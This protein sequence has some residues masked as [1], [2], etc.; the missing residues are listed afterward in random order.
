MDLAEMSSWDFDDYIDDSPCE[1]GIFEHDFMEDFVDEPY[2]DAVIDLDDYCF[3]DMICESNDDD[4]VSKEDLIMLMEDLENESI[5]SDWIN[6]LDIMDAEIN[7]EKKPKSRFSILKSLFP[8]PD[9][10]VIG[11]PSK[12]MSIILPKEKDFEAWKTVLT[13][14]KCESDAEVLVTEVAAILRVHTQTGSTTRHVIL[15][16]IN[17]TEKSAIRRIYKKYKIKDKIQDGSRGVVTVNRLVA[18][19]PE[20]MAAGLLRNPQSRWCDLYRPCPYF[21]CFPAAASLIPVRDTEL[22]QAHQNWARCF[23]VTVRHREFQECFW[24][25]SLTN[26]LYTTGPRTDVLQVLFA[27]AN[28]LNDR[29]LQ[30]C[31]N[32]PAISDR[33]WM[34]TADT[35]D[36][37]QSRTKRWKEKIPELKDNDRLLHT[38]RLESQLMMATICGEHNGDDV[39]KETLGNASRDP[40]T[41]GTGNGLNSQQSNVH[42]KKKKKKKKKVHSWPN[43]EKTWYKQ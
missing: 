8:R 10:D 22:K 42:T 15:N 37:F 29:R 12:G 5:T 31:H 3:D 40:D 24:Q 2:Q 43:P 33:Y 13:L 16:S 14:M 18:T 34:S 23:D 26:S 11:L 4:R 32:N 25:A 9:P 39:V 27:Y 19:F 1:A 36:S 6:G 28:N 30:Q 17:A 20:I 41:N 7:K 35:L 38:V 21:L